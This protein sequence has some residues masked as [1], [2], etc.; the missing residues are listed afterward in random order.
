VILRDAPDKFGT[1]GTMAVAISRRTLL[2]AGAR[3]EPH[4]LPVQGGEWV[5]REIVKDVQSGRARFVVN[6]GDAI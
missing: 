6:S 5:T 3:R 4:N 2:A 1:P